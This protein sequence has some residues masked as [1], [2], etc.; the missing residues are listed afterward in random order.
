MTKELKNVPE[1]VT[2]IVYIL[3]GL[4][5]IFF[6]EYIMPAIPYIFGTLQCLVG[7]LAIIKYFV[8]K[9]YT[10]NESALLVWA[11]INIAVCLVFILHHELGLDI[12]AL[13]W[14][15]H[16][17]INA[18][19]CFHKIL[20][21]ISAKQKWLMFLIEGLIE[22]VLGV[23]LLIEFSEGLATHIVILGVYL[24][25]IGLFGLFGVKIKKDNKKHLHSKRKKFSTDIANSNT[26]NLEKRSQ[27]GT[28]NSIDKK[29]TTDI[30]ADSIES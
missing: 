6:S 1:T 23:M 28:N 19:E 14:G 22:L 30:S 17:I 18:V 24:A 16:A 3:V 20:Y 26:I 25:L 5:C 4:V 11:G 21:S 7:L 27:S 10:D 15:I 8:K 29:E 12:F 13:F 2:N 9:K